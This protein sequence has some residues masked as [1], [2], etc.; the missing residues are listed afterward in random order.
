MKREVGQASSAHLLVHAVGRPEPVG[1]REVSGDSV[2]SGGE[3]RVPLV[4]E[5]TMHPLTLRRD[6]EAGEREH[7]H[8][9]EQGT[10]RKLD[11]H[12]PQMPT[13][14]S[15]RCCRSAQGPLPGGLVVEVWENRVSE[16]AGVR[17][18]M[19]SSKLEL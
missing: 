19:S 10:P 4:A 5:L 13:P 3:A 14:W 18:V 11:R 8:R 6:Q 9:H 17:E 1:D 15:C 12:G 2:A 16:S 7:Q